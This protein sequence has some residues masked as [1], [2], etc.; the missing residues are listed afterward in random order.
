MNMKLVGIF[1]CMLLTT[2]AMTTI[3]TNINKNNYNELKIIKPTD[4]PDEW[5]EGAD[6]YQTDKYLN[7]TIHY[8]MIV[9][10]SFYV[11]QEFKP[12]KD[13]LTAVA[14]YLFNVNAPANI[15]IIVSIRDALDGSDLTVTTVSA[16]DKNIKKGG[17]WVMFDFNDITVIP[18]ETYYIVCHASDGGDDGNCYCWIFNVDNAYDRGIAWATDDTGENW[19]NLEETPWGPEFVELDL[20][21]ITYFQKPPK[22]KPIEI[23]LFLQELFHRFPIFEKILNQIL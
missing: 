22:M 10:P 4:V 17:T 8:G 13:N 1:I 7:G 15:D 9:N 14:L 16:D 5:L 21:F 6:Q 11:A 18:E 12:T 20:C 3:A 23:N 19:Y 2:S